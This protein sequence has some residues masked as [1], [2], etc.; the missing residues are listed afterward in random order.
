MT[1]TVNFPFGAGVLSPSTGI[2]LNNEMDDFSTPTEITPDQLPPAPAN[3]IKPNKR[4]LSSMTPIIVTKVKEIKTAI[5]FFGWAFVLKLIAAL[6]LL[7][8]LPCQDNQLVGVIGGSG[9]MDII[10]AVVQVFINHFLLGLEP[11]AA[12][13]NPRVYHKVSDFFQYINY[14]I[15]FL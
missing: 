1:T 7:C 11:L 3:F 14:N 15:F 13:Q 8:L 10:P 6:Y 12:V 4:P 9:G 5:F 2:V